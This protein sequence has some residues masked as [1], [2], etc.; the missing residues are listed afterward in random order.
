MDASSL[1]FSMLL[2]CRLYFL[3]ILVSISACGFHRTQSANNESSGA[4]PSPQVLSE[5][6]P[7]KAVQS[8]P[9]EREWKNRFVFRPHS[10]SEKH[11]G[12]CPYELSAEY[13][14]AASKNIAV[15]R[16]NRWIRRKVL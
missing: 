1:C 15:K 8:R 10:I 16:F 13:P 9:I 7:Q 11:D 4:T 12:Y 3:S 2:V 14:E 6:A 5:T